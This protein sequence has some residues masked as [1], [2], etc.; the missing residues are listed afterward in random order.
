LKH[1]LDREDVVWQYERIALQ[2]STEVRKKEVLIECT[3][4]LGVKPK[5]PPFWT[6]RPLG[7]KVLHEE[8]QNKL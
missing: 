1:L 5:L 3:K 6:M 8:C 7:P 2:G 4:P